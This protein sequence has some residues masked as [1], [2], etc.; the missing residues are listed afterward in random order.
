MRARCLAFL[1]AASVLVIGWAG[2]AS[3]QQVK[4]LTFWSHW[5]AEVPKRT[6]VEEAIKQFEAKNPGIKIKPTWYEKT[7][8]YAGLKTALRAGQAPDI[9]YAEP[10]QAE[11]MENGFLLD[12]SALN[13]ADVEPWAK[14]AWTYQGQ[15]VRPAAGSLDRRALLQ[16]EADGGPRRERAGQL[17]AL[18]G[19][20]PRH[21]Q[22]GEGQGH[23]ADG[24]RRRRPA[25]SRARISCTRR[26]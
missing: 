20:V 8:L 11:Y 12:L 4:E 22:E 24:A 14:E 7:A 17:A 6:F 23:H 10:D 25:L 21:G 26:C 16:Q 2:T 5:A 1:I 13:W 3:A 19:R 18:P 15:A 9:F